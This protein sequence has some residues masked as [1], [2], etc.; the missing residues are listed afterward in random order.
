M[1]PEVGASVEW[2]ASRQMDRRT[3]ESAEGPHRGVAREGGLISTCSTKHPGTDW[4][5]TKK[6]SGT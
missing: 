3:V 1:S 5:L 4:V 6:L 2:A